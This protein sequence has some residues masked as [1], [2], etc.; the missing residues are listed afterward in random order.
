[1]PKTKSRIHQSKSASPTLR[2][3]KAAAEKEYQGALD[4]YIKDRGRRRAIGKEL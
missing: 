2:Q 3:L 4:R 1:M